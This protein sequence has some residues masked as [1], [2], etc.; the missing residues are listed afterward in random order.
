MIIEKLRA[1]NEEPQRGDIIGRRPAVVVAGGSKFN[2]CFPK[3][4]HS[5]AELNDI[6][7]PRSLRLGFMTVS[8]A[9]LGGSL[10]NYKLEPVGNKGL[11]KFN[12]KTNCWC[13]KRVVVFNS[14][15]YGVTT[16][17]FNG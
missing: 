10:R 9:A 7:I 11:L 16:I 15:R 14:C 6:K 5:R 4:G 17:C 13:Y 3:S 2:I 1:R 12:Y 8:C